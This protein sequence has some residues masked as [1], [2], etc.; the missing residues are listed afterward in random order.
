[1]L[2]VRFRA[3]GFTVD[4]VNKFFEDPDGNTAKMMGFPPGKEMAKIQQLDPEEG[5][6][7]KWVRL[8]LPVPGVS[9]RSQVRDLYRSVPV[10][11]ATYGLC[12]SFAAWLTAA[13]LPAAGDRSP[14]EGARRRILAGDQ[15]QQAI[16][17]HSRRDDR[18]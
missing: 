12:A 6:D 17:A 5:A 3:E 11:I 16:P 13:A 10:C 4:H 8:K 14:Q 2:M 15:F 9:P 7:I 1:M 18:K